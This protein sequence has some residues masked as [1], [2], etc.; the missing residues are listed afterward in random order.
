VLLRSD[1]K[2]LVPETGRPNNYLSASTVVEKIL[3]KSEHI[4]EEMLEV[5]FHII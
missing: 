5:T 2:P 3:K 4:L 1:L